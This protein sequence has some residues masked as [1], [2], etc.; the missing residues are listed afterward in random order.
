MIEFIVEFGI[1]LLHSK[2]AAVSYTYTDVE[3]IND[4]L[5]K[6]KLRDVLS[7]ALAIYQRCIIEEQFFKTSYNEALKKLKY[8]LIDV[9]FNHYNSYV[10]SLGTYEEFAMLDIKDILLL[11]D[12]ICT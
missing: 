1:A 9:L 7:N 8:S 11:L 6:I 3:N 5:T 2:V 4:E 10:S 12:E